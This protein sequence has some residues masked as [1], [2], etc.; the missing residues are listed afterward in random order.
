VV[1]GAVPRS[2]IP[3]VEKGARDALA[4]GGPQGH[5]VV[6]VRVELYDGKAHSVDSS[7]MAFRTAASIGV[8]AA[9]VAAGTLVLEPVSIVTITVPAELQGPVLTDLSSRRARVI[10]T[11]STDDGGTRIVA[12]APDAELG[13]YVLDLRSLTGGQAQL[14]IAP[15]R[16]ER[17]PGAAK[18]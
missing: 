3:A 13:R 18:S 15:D 1:G 10:A 14:E 9:L 16:Y 6:D 5:P 4:A 17:A 11:E 7:E 12:S 8:K 2:Y